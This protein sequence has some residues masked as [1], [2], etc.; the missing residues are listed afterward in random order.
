MTQATFALL[1][2]SLALGCRTTADPETAPPSAAAAPEAI[3]AQEDPREEAPAAA[4]SGSDAFSDFNG[5]GIDDGLDIAS[6]TSLD[7]NA[8]G[9]PD[10][11]EEAWALAESST[12]A[13]AGWMPEANIDD[14]NGNGIDDIMEIATGLADDDNLN[15]IPDDCEL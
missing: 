10:E 7:E 2:L 13:S 12:P 5:N 6:M 15:G 14:C 1:T 8:N 4:A 3:T 11:A 9:V